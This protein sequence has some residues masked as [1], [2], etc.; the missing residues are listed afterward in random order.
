MTNYS[1]LICDMYVVPFP[2][3]IP[4]AINCLEAGDENMVG[5]KTS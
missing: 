4:P 2:L 1:C 3:V 5:N